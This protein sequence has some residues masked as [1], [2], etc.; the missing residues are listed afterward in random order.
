MNYCQHIM[1]IIV[2]FPFVCSFVITVHQVQSVCALKRNTF[3]KI[4]AAKAK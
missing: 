4:E 2:I 1:E 3:L